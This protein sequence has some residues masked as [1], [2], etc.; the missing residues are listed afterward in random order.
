MERIRKETEVLGMR[1][2]SSRNRRSWLGVW[3]VVLAACGL[4]GCAHLKTGLATTAIV[5]ATTALLPAAIVA[6]A[7]LGGITAATVSAITAEPRIKG[8]PIT[9][10]ADTVV[11]EAPANFWTLLGQLIE[12]GGWALILIVIVPM[13]FSWLMPGPIQFKKK[14]GS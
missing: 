3:L 8:E 4:T 2:C 7:V 11:Q 13:V 9:V 10:T 14:N 6:P 12:M 1:R 5:S